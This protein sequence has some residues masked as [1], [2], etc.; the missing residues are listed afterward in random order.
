MV[1]LSL[2]HPLQALLIADEYKEDVIIGKKKIS[3]RE[4]LR[5]Y[6]A[7]QPL[8]ICDSE[9]SFCVKT[10]LKKVRHCKAEAVTEQEY[11]ADN[12][13]S[14]EEMLKDLQRFYPNFTSESYVTI[15]SWDNVSGYLVNERKK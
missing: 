7:G 14:S 5:N 9:T 3:I 4:G 1:D 12:Y 10:D 11:R 8:M 2:K 6:I 15:L 13:S